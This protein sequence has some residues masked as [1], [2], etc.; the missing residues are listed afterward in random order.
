MRFT[1]AIPPWNA[2]G[3]LPPADPSSPTSSDRSPYPVAL[4]DLVLRFTETVHRRSILEGFLDYRAAL[5]VAGLTRGFQW[6]DG[7]FVEQVEAGSRKR[8]PA[9]IDVVT[10]FRLPSGMTQEELI[11]AA[12]DLFPNDAD[13]RF[14]LKDR[15]KV[16][17]Y[18]VNLGLASERLVDRAA[19]WS[20]LW[21]HQR[22]TF[23]WKGFLQVD[24]SPGE[25]EV[26]RRMLEQADSETP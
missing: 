12:E 16:D 15:Y 23:A 20:S 8:S 17:A 5:H 25:D 18:A 2:D 13:S 19:Y 14:A 1:S 22:E 10:F 7:S 11:A 4:E 3:L 26:A 6:I 9:D 24:L 21:G